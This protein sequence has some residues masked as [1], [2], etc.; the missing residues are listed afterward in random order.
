MKGSRQQLSSKS[1]NPPTL[2]IIGPQNDPL[3][4]T[5]RKTF[6]QAG[7][8]TNPTDIDAPLIQS[9]HLAVGIFRAIDIRAVTSFAKW[10]RLAGL[11]SVCAGLLNNVWVLGPLTCSDHPGCIQCAI[12][13]M[14][15]AANGSLSFE[16]STE[17]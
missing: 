16:F 7:A 1:G 12:N 3:V 9:A 4:L 10:A 14:V 5:L 17:I 6:K 15:A 2:L 11:P 8:F 13:R